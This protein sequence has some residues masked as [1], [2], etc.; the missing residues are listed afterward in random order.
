[1]S[2]NGRSGVSMLVSCCFMPYSGQQVINVCRG[3]LLTEAL[4]LV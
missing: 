1:M 3:S 2:G 4:S